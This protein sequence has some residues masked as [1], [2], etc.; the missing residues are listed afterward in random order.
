MHDVLD[1]HVD[2]SYNRIAAC[3]SYSYLVAIYRRE[4]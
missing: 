4:L 2:H 3:K 1:V